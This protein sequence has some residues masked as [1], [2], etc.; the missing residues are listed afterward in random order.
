MKRKEVKEKRMKKRKR[1]KFTGYHNPSPI[2]YYSTLCDSPLT[3]LS[4]CA[5]A[6][7]GRAA[8]RSCRSDS[9]S[10]SLTMA[11]CRT[12]RILNHYR[13]AGRHKLCILQTSTVGY[14]HTARG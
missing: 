2:F 12:G 4:S 7:T 6:N 14:P 11:R 1:K 9:H 10:L 8:G 3:L 13:S 5:C